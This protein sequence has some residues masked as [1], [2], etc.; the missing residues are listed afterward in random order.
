MAVRIAT[1]KNDKK[2][3]QQRAELAVPES[4]TS[5]LVDT[6]ESDCRDSS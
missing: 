2:T 1:L 6:L 3:N 4:V 5:I